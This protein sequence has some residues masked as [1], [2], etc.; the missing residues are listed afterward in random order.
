MSF[1]REPLNSAR[2]DDTNSLSCHR[3][4]IT[5]STI[6][7]CRMLLRLRDYA[8][9]RVFGDTYLSTNTSVMATIDIPLGFANG[10]SNI[11]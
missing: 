1:L 5:F 2:C 10:G 3:L 9:R 8:K 6:L 11:E 7:S 4:M